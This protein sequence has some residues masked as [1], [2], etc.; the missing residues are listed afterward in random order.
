M[1][2]SSTKRDYY[3]VLGIARGA[4]D[5]D[6]KR[7]YRKLALQFHPDRNKAPDAEV[8]FKEVTEAYQVLSDSDKRSLYDRY[9][10]AAF[11]RNGGGADF[12]NFSGLNIEDIF[13]SFFG[14]AG[15]RGARQ[16]VQRGQ[17]LR[18]DLTITL[19]EAVFGTTRE[20]TLNQHVTCTR[21]TGN[22]LEPGTQPERCP[23]CNGSG[24]IRRVQQSI[25]GQFVNVTLCD[26]CNGEG[27]VIA[28]PCSEC[29]GRGVVRAKRTLSVAV[30][31]G[32]EDGLQ[33]R[34]SGEGE[35]APRG[36]PSGHLYVVLHVQ[37]H[38]YFKR[39]GN[40][41]LVEVPINV[42]QAALGDEFKVPTLDGK[43]LPI[44]VPAG[45]Q[46]GRIV[47]LRGEGVP[48]L[49]EHGRG[50]LQ[51]HLRVKTPTELSEEQ[52]RLF[53]QLGATFGSV[54]TEPNENKSFF[55]KV[56]DVFGGS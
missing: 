54:K 8:R 16:R 47:R 17:D 37:P 56:K 51:V 24:E 35:P 33:L 53:Q 12:S 20:I 50:D 5:D 1:P 42:A 22:G 44:K 10:H 40:D 21:C 3:E 34:L 27:S 15:S 32:S 29:Q 19:E 55:D 31:Q 23:R 18:Y 11:E 48:Y 41:L 6:I 45:T 43:E 7:A 4:S 52:R 46:S 25:F 30:P 39:H 38:K 49:R 28:N 13:E 2:S 36:G 26:R 9:G 14:V